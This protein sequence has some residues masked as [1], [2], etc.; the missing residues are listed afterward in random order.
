[1]TAVIAPT[2]RLGRNVSIGHHV[3]VGDNSAIGDEVTLGHGVIVHADTR[4]GP[5][6]RVDDHAVLGKRP[7]SAAISILK[8]AAELPPLEIGE[9]CFEVK[10]TN[11]DTHL[12]GDDFD[13]RVIRWMVEEF[14]RDQGIDLSKDRMALQRLKEAA[15]KAKCE[16]STTLETEINLPFVTADAS[17]P[18][19]LNLKLTRAK[20]EQLVE[21]LVQRTIGPCRQALKDAGLQSGQIDEVVLV[22]GQTRM[23]RVQQLV[24]ERG[25]DLAAWKW[26]KTN[27]L[28]LHSLTQQA[29]LDRGGVVVRGDEFTL[30]PG[31]DGGGPVTGGASWRMVVDL[32]DPGHSFGVFPGGESENPVSPHYDDQ[33]NPWAAGQYLPLYFYSTPEGFQAGQVESILVLTPR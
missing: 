24:K 27:V 8:V 4:I 9:G 17:G 5:G 22:G 11:G 7:R 2:A 10:S 1:M 31:D 19:H 3:V 32:A 18:K 14:K 33:V 26:G 25:P 16:L 6:T 23:P 28:R 29:A 15:E 12:G 21:D 30:C 20:L 13:D